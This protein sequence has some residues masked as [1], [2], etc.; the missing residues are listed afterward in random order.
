MLIVRDLRCFFCQKKYVPCEM[1]V[2]CREGTLVDWRRVRWWTGGGHFGGLGEGSLV[3]W[4]RA[5]WWTGRE[6]FGGLGEGTLVDWWRA[7]WWTGREFVGGLG[8]GTLV[9]WKLPLDNIALSLLIIM[10]KKLKTKHKR[11]VTW[12]KPDT[13]CN[14]QTTKSY[15]FDGLFLQNYFIPHLCVCV[16]S[17]ARARAR[18][19]LSN[20][21]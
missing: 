18:N 21:E 19:P 14:F 17:R 12:R 11:I 10:E 8:E 15:N 1:A 5:R 3:D 20:S 7:R 9:D 2:G 4:E 13:A 16:R 6:F